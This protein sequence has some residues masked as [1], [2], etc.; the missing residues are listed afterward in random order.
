M[1]RTGMLSLE[2]MIGN[3]S[4]ATVTRL[5]PRESVTK[6][7][8]GR[9]RGWIKQ[10]FYVHTLCPLNLAAHN[11]IIDGGTAFLALG[12]RSTGSQQGGHPLSLPCQCNDQLLAGFH[13]LVIPNGHCR[14]LYY[15]YSTS[16]RVCILFILSDERKK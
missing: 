16:K 13:G 14:L 1:D 11:N 10:T 2:H 6:R 8:R 5:H 9:E 3:V 15:Q 12:Q 4:I 7:A